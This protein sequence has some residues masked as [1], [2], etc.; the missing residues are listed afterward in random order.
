LHYTIIDNFLSSTE[1]KAVIEMAILRL[2]PSFSWNVGKR[3]SEFSDYRRSD[4]MFFQLGENELIR[5]I[6]QKITDHTHIP[7]ENGEGLQVVRYVTAKGDTIRLTGT[8][9]I[10]NG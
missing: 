2:E 5:H 7:I 3:V 8:I 4:Q 1:C 10:R 9:L 6:E